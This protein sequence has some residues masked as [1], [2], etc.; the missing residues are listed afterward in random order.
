M[1]PQIIMYFFFP[2]TLL[3][4]FLLIKNTQK[5]TLLHFLPAIFSAAIGTLLYVQ[6]L[7]TNGLNEFVLMIYFAGIAL[8]NLF[9]ILVL[10]L[11]Q[12]FLSRI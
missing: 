5:K 1:L 3:A 9:L 7:F 8:A 12:S 2:I 10:K 4:T 6:F 11:F